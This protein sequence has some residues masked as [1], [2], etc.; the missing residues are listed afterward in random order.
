MYNISIKNKKGSA[1]RNDEQQAIEFLLALKDP[2]TITPSSF[3]EIFQFATE[4]PSVTTLK[5]F[6]PLPADLKEQDDGLLEASCKAALC[7][8]MKQLCMA[9]NYGWRARALQRIHNPQSWFEFLIQQ[10]IPVP[11]EALFTAI[12]TSDS[13]LL[14]RLLTNKFEQE[15]ASDAKTTQ[16]ETLLGDLLVEAATVGDAW[17]TESASTLDILLEYVPRILSDQTSL[18]PDVASLCGHYFWSDTSISQ[19][20]VNFVHKALFVALKNGRLHAAA[21]LF[22]AQQQFSFSL[23]KSERDEENNTILMALV[24]T[25]AF[26]SPNSYPTIFAQ[27]FNHFLATDD[28]DL[29]AQ[30]NDGLTIFTLD[31][32]FAETAFFPRVIEK[33]CSKS[34]IVNGELIADKE[35]LKTLRVDVG[36]DAKFD[37]LDESCLRSKNL[38]THCQIQAEIKILLVC[39]FFAKYILLR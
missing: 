18:A 39:R 19:S 21:R 4:A 14:Q 23:T 20:T 8:K 13:S 25:Q 24:K 34:K 27:L 37:P 28:V 15:E 1:I 3:P 5:R 30:N 33:F 2:K 10:G 31:R 7:S 32:H 38:S 9:S 22:K 11:D 17:L 26:L 6:Y 35:R 16:S 12:K 29:F 36:L